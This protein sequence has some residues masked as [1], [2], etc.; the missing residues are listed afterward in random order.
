MVK[1]LLLRQS[2]V[3]H[4]ISNAKKREDHMQPSY[5]TSYQLMLFLAQEPPHTSLPYD[6]AN[7]LNQQP[8][9]HLHFFFQKKNLFTIC[10]RILILIFFCCHGVKIC[11]TKI[12]VGGVFSLLFVGTPPTTLPSSLLLYNGQSS[13]WDSSTS[14]YPS[15][16][17]LYTFTILLFIGVHCHG[18]VTYQ[19]FMI[20]TFDSIVWDLY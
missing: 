2:H 11:P 15:L 16:F 6:Q 13:L 5:V 17:V 10:T 20:V 3:K 9:G 19:L 12:L 18:Y 14:T 4:F 1:V 8:L 7:K